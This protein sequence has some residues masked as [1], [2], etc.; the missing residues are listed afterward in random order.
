[1]DDKHGLGYY[2]RIT[3]EHAPKSTSNFVSKANKLN[4]NYQTE[5]TQ[6]LFV[7]GITVVAIYHI[8][9]LNSST[10]NIVIT[11]SAA[12]IYAFVV[13]YVFIVLEN[14]RIEDNEELASKI[15]P[16]SNLLTE[17]QLD[18]QANK[19]KNMIAIA[20]EQSFNPEVIGLYVVCALLILGPIVYTN[21]SASALSLPVRVVLVIQI[22]FF[23]YYT[24][25][26]RYNSKSSSDGYVKERLN[27]E[28][29][30]FIKDADEEK[31]TTCYPYAYDEDEGNICPTGFYDIGKCCACEVVPPCPKGMVEK[32]G[33]CMNIT[34]PAKN[35]PVN[36]KC[37]DGWYKDKISNVV[38]ES[39]QSLEGQYGKDEE[40]CYFDA[41]PTDTMSLA[42]DIG[43]ELAV[44]LVLGASITAGSKTVKSAMKYASKKMGKKVI[45][46]AGL[47]SFGKAM[48]KKMATKSGRALVRASMKA[49]AK[50]MAKSIASMSMRSMAKKLGMNLL[51]KGGPLKMMAKMGVSKAGGKA[52]QAASKAAAKAAAKTAAKAAT[53]KV[54]TKALT[55]GLTK[56]KPSP[57]IIFDVASM[58]LDILDPAGYSNQ[59]NNDDFFYMRVESDKRQKSN[60]EN[61]GMD[62]PS[63]MYFDRLVQDGDVEEIEDGVK[64]SRAEAKLNE[65]I[66]GEQEQLLEQFADTN[67]DIILG[68]AIKGLDILFNDPKADE[69]PSSLA[70]SIFKYWIDNMIKD[71]FFSETD[72]YYSDV[73]FRQEAG[74]TLVSNAP[75]STNLGGNEI[76]NTNWFQVKLN[77]AYPSQYEGPYKIKNIQDNGT[78]ILSK[79]D[80]NKKDEEKYTDVSIS[81]KN[82][83]FQQLADVKL[84]C[85]SML[86][87]L[88]MEGLNF[89]E[90]EFNQIWQAVAVINIEDTKAKTP[91]ITNREF[92]KQIIGIVLQ[93]YRTKY[94]SSSLTEYICEE[95]TDNGFANK[96]KTCSK[97]DK[98]ELDKFLF[99]LQL[100]YIIDEAFLNTSECSP[101]KIREITQNVCE[102]MSS[103]KAKLVYR[104]GIWQCIVNNKTMCNSMK[105][106]DGDN[107]IEYEWY[108]NPIW[109]LVKEGDFERPDAGEGM[110]L[111]LE[112][113]LFPKDKFRD[114]FCT[115]ANPT[116]M[117]V[118]EGRM[119]CKNTWG[120]CA[121]PTENNFKP[122]CSL[123]N[124]E[125]Q[126]MC[127]Q[128][129]I[130]GWDKPL[131]YDKAKRQC[132]TQRGYCTKMG[133]GWKNNDCNIDMALWLCEQLIGTT[134]CRSVGKLEKCSAKNDIAAGLIDSCP[135]GKTKIGALCYK[136][137]PTGYSRGK[138]VNVMNC[139]K[140]CPAGWVTDTVTGNCKKPTARVKWCKSGEFHTVFDGCYVYKPYYKN[141]ND[142]KRGVDGNCYEWSSTSM[143]PKR[144]ANEYNKV[145]E[146]E[147]RSKESGVV[148]VIPETYCPSGYT[149]GP[150]SLDPNKQCRI[151]TGL[152]K[153]CPGGYTK[154]YIAGVPWCRK[155][156]GK[157]QNYGSCKGSKEQ[158]I[159]GSKVK[160]K[161]EENHK[162]M[163]KTEECVDLP[164]KCTTKRECTNTTCKRHHAKKGWWDIAPACRDWN[165]EC[166]DVPQCQ[167]KPDRK[168]IRVGCD[169]P[170]KRGFSNPRAKDLNC[171]QD[172]CTYDKWN[173]QNMKA[174]YSLDSPR[175]EKGVFNNHLYQMGKLKECNKGYKKGGGIDGW[176]GDHCYKV[177]SET[178][179]FKRY[180]TCPK[181]EITYIDLLTRK[182]LKKTVQLK[183]NLLNSTNKN[184]HCE[185][186]VG[187]QY[188]CPSGYKVSNDPFKD[189]Q[190]SCYKEVGK[191]ACHTVKIGGKDVKTKDV[192]GLCHY[193][194]PSGYNDVLGVA[195][196]R[197]VHPD[198]KYYDSGT[199]LTCPP[200]L[201]QVALQCMHKC[202]A[203]NK[204]LPAKTRNKIREEGGKWSNK[205][206]IGCWK[207]D[208]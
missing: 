154:E 63:A 106:K 8:N 37:K 22:N 169:C 135:A 101:N 115:K 104:D 151:Q 14:K 69:T 92:A 34:C 158:K 131:T 208:C 140:N 181:K 112:G 61:M 123:V 146:D 89:T 194:C 12:L 68:E 78:V 16:I 100:D 137:C 75:L 11:S 121:K 128:K 31:N 20:I 129:A 4:A 84:K 90:V 56:L 197:P 58:V 28:E 107:T 144:N 53:K 39:G 125:A 111:F 134:V 3:N 55:K 105:V 50:S 175:F 124:S 19:N 118:P 205:P 48:Y 2:L 188:T 72:D 29:S 10:S 189:K 83:V 94:L 110:K 155:D 52:T 18:I 45:T 6:S 156:Y 157:A 166:I 98:Y 199:T 119:G 46:K 204:N 40:C 160:C 23:F 190:K 141:C 47:K 33:C 87:D 186:K 76:K 126:E 177:G 159:E 95:V 198:K 51:A 42:K 182:K 85:R 152:N 139:Y 35:K 185:Y 25:I 153:N 201:E 36:G 67:K 44:G 62:M 74:N 130:T 43:K 183:Q 138:G 148:T 96:R 99:E 173:T 49:S 26:V 91:N 203:D 66:Y 191:R 200:H 117:Y 38:G 65:L 57:L 149:K 170:G 15:S 142:D 162:T 122:F 178:R 179:I 103:N 120:C 13:Y 80:T 102:K 174:N 32:K 132:L 82:P 54:V 70:N 133:V 147:K 5:L 113:K 77:G 127:S 86:L 79:R 180:Y 164:L 97:T 145:I 41:D 73:F 171:L 196:E 81:F 64:I 108:E 176:L 116:W 143:T 206:V 30:E 9:I 167:A 21:P 165:R 71:T 163:K 7:G 195:C 172:Y 88:F 168:C 136:N 27:A 59:K 114:N 187:P 24:Y 192:L 1:M 161:F 184:R 109:E 207:E 202:T 60:F 193:E 17:I 93:Q 150:A